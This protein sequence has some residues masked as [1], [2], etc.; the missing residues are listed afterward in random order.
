MN[1]DARTE[2]FPAVRSR[3]DPSTN[4]GYQVSGT[5]TTRPRGARRVERPQGLQAHPRRR[6]RALPRTTSDAAHVRIAAV[7]GRPITYVSQ[8]LGH[9]DAAITPRV[10]THWLPSASTY[11]LFNRPDDGA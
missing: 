4:L 9:R 11:T 3:G 6:G 2:Q 10:Y 1:T 7:A 8:Q 5:E